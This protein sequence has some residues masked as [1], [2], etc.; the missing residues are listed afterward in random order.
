M[1]S[2]IELWMT[3]SVAFQST[4]NGRVVT[5][6]LICKKTWD[7]LYREHKVDGT[8]LGAGSNQHRDGDT[9]TSNR[10]I[11]QGHAY[12]ILRLE[13]VDGHKMMQLRN[14]WGRKEWS[15]AWSDDSEL[16]TTRMRNKLDFHAIEDEGIFWMTFADFVK[17]FVT[18]YFCR[19]LTESKGWKNVNV[20][21]KWAGGRTG[22]ICTHNN[23]DGDIKR[24]PQYT[25]TISEPGRGFFVFR[26]KERKESTDPDKPGK[27]LGSHH[28]GYMEIMEN[29]GKVIE[30]RSTGKR[31]AT[32]GPHYKLFSAAEVEFDAKL[33]FPYTFTCAVA[34]EAEGASGEGNFSL[35]VYSK[36]MGM[37]VKKL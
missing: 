13:L 35:Q 7:K 16:W 20:L 17:E 22:G 3:S 36:D 21:D 30:E 6:L 29:N 2:C 23:L 25:V 18:I 34:N 26:M 1:D 33:T 31:L 15:G 5:T 24:A 4:S 10:G 8:Y 12:S 19:S 28:M 32:V 14:P 11:V 9:A 37:K 27:L